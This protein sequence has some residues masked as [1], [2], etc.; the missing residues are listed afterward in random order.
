MDNRDKFFLLA[1]RT[2]DE[3]VTITLY[4]PNLDPDSFGSEEKA[5][6]AE[7]EDAETEDV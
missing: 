5:V 6:D 4:G 2:R 3:V 7:A 1:N